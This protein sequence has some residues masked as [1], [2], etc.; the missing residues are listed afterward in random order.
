MTKRIGVLVA[1][2]AMAALVVFTFRGGPG[3]TAAGE[4][5]SVAPAS[6]SAGIGATVTVNIDVASVI[7]LAGFQCDLSWDS[8]DLS[9][10]TIGNGAFLTG[11]WDAISWVS[12]VS[13]LGT[14]VA[15]NADKGIRFM[16]SLT[17]PPSMDSARA[18]DGGGTMAVLTFTRTGGTASTVNLDVN[19][20]SLSVGIPPS[21]V[22][23]VEN[24]GTVTAPT[25]V[26]DG[27][28]ND[29]DTLVDEG[30]L[31][32]D[33][34]GIA[35]CVDTDDDGDGV[36]DTDEVLYGS[37]PLDDASTPESAIYDPAT[38]ADGLDNDLDTAADSADAGC[39]I[40]VS[41]V[42]PSATIW[43]DKVA[44]LWADPNYS[45][46]ASGIP[47]GSA[48]AFELTLVYDP[49]VMSVSMAE[50]PDWVTA[51]SDCAM[52][53]LSETSIRFGCAT[54]GAVPV[55]PGPGGVSD[56]VQ[57]SVSRN[58][59]FELL[60]NKG[61]GATRALD[62]R[63]VKIG[64]PL[65]KPQLIGVVNDETVVVKALEGDNNYSCNVDVA[66]DGQAVAGR[67]GIIQGQA[68]Y[69]AVYD[70]QGIVIGG[71][72]ETWLGDGDIDIL[73]VQFVFG[74]DGNVCS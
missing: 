41:L 6:Q 51:G 21:T 37:D 63:S 69:E 29:F 4:A 40:M 45:V 1:L 16:S 27:A 46:E 20:C 65:G 66:T 44:P 60:P 24:D 61:N 32:T 14:Q 18:P 23:A 68:L 3:A 13:G 2:A 30:F 47:A 70:L 43:I 52:V 53:I 33:L 15:V 28:D 8:A 55:I 64:D 67:F 34:D 7:D 11:T 26:C 48:S 56:L 71:P 54:A 36:S 19:D 74:R 73:D 38:C 72:P 59:D 62:L 10:Q 9:W 58:P 57:G 25:E 39:G 49:N 17:V 50:G 22:T 31:D 35:D 12:E 42:A 5:V